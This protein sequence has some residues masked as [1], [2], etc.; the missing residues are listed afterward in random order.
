MFAHVLPESTYDE[1]TLL[2]VI[3]W[4]NSLVDDCDPLV[5]YTESFIFMDPIGE[6]LYDDLDV[7]QYWVPAFMNVASQSMPDVYQRF[8]QLHLELPEKEFCDYAQKVIEN[9]MPCE[10]HWVL[11]DPSSLYYILY[12]AYGEDWGNPDWEQPYGLEPLCELFGFEYDEDMAVWENLYDNDARNFA[13]IRIIEMLEAT[14]EPI[15][16]NVA[17]LIRWMFVGTGNTYAD[18]S[19]QLM[20]EN[21]IEPFYWSQLEYAEKVQFEAR[22]FFDMAMS[23]RDALN[24]DVMLMHALMS[25]YEMLY[26]TFATD[27]EDEQTKGKTHVDSCPP[28]SLHFPEPNC[29]GEI[30]LTESQASY[31]RL[32]LW[33]DAPPR[34]PH[35]RH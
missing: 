21:G 35:L 7:D 9:H 17:M 32:R 26:R 29:E 28:I 27:L 18:Y 15:F 6:D 10:D 16:H 30:G 2:D 19:L 20:Q 23:G 25:N 14:D 33:R 11:D 5:E 13:C 12:D 31:Q 4:L 1:P 8:I 24:N 22:E 3:P 34:E